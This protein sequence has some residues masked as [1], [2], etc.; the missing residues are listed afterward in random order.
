VN[1]IQRCLT[2]TTAISYSSLNPEPAVFT[3]IHRIYLRT[4]SILY[5]L[6]C[7]Y[8]QVVYSLH[9]EYNVLHTLHS[10]HAC[11]IWHETGPLGLSILITCGKDNSWSSSLWNFLHLLW[12]LF[13]RSEYLPQQSVLNLF[14]V[15]YGCFRRTLND[16][17]KTFVIQPSEQH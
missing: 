10:S 7:L 8:L 9:R 13:L 12:F 11:Y 3:A 16:F 4:V 14:S 5:S 17:Q 2:T 1:A 15:I 6:M